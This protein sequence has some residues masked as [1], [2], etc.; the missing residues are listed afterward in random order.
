[1]RVHRQVDR[2]RRRILMGVVAVSAFGAGAV[3]DGLLHDRI[4]RKLNNIPPCAIE[5]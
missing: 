4:N 2:A 1:M 3:D 5:P